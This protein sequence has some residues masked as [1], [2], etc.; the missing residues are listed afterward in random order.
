MSVILHCWLLWPRFASVEPGLDK[1]IEDAATDALALHCNLF[2]E[3]NRDH[4]RAARIDD[5]EGAA[6]DLGFA[7][8]AA[9]G[10]ADLAAAQHQH[11]RPHLTRHRPLALHHRRHRHR[12]TLF[13][14][15]HQFLKEFSHDW[16][17]KPESYPE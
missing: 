17:S 3:V 12:L 11:L 16:F 10:A 1:D 5:V 6:P 8:A 13:H 14:L 4:V 15:L 2:C 7:A 9:D